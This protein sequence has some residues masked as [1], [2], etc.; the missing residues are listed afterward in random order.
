[1]KFLITETTEYEVAAD[2]PEQAEEIFLDHGPSGG[3]APMVVFR[4]VTDRDLALLND[5]EEDERRTTFVHNPEG[6]QPCPHAEHWRDCD[7][8]NGDER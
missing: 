2:S 6:G 5:Q 4:G 7:I 3:E 1:M 8:C